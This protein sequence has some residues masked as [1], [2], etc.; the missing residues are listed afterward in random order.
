MFKSVGLIRTVVSRIVRAER[1]ALQDYEQGRTQQ[2]P[3]ITD[4]LI[5]YIQLNLNGKRFSG[6]D[7]KAVTLPDRG[8]RSAESQLGADLLCALELRLNGFSVSKGFLVQAKKI[9]PSHPFRAQDYQEL[10]A[11]CE[12]ML[13]ISGASF[14]FL[15]SL[16]S[17]IRVVP[18]ISIVGARSCNPHELE[19]ISLGECFM[20]HFECFLGD[21]RLAPAVGK[22]LQHLLEEKRAK[23]VLLISGTEAD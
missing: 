6:I 8:P 17:G 11:Q 4:R 10:K 16:Q 23:R 19:S 22:T 14:V 3:Q 5:A 9:E 7:W 1:L 12:K 2:E 20:V 15:Y 21:R 13:D 18:A